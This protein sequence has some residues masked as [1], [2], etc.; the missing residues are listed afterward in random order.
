MVRQAAVVLAAI[1]WLASP[2]AFADE[3]ATEPAK[4][5]VVIEDAKGPP[6]DELFVPGLHVRH[7]PVPIFNNFERWELWTMGTLAV[8]LPLSI[9]FQSEIA[10]WRFGGTLIGSPPSF[11]VEISE[12]L[13]SG[14][15]PPSYLEGIDKF[16]GIVVPIAASL[17]YLSDGVVTA[18]RG[19]GF[20]GDVYSLHHALA[21]G[22]AFLF[23]GFVTQLGKLGIGRLRPRYELGRVPPD[24]G[25]VETF[26]SFPSGHTSI[27]FCVGS[28]L[29]RDLGDYLVNERGW[30]LWAGRIAPGVVIYSIALTIAYQRVADQDHYFSDVLI[31]AALGTT[32][33]HW[34]YSRHFDEHGHPRHNRGRKIEIIAGPTSVGVQGSF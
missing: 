22:E 21:F 12:A 5:Q 33:G 31:G 25:D 13:W 6:Q 34:I 27:S 4:P 29:F 18:A 8:A 26:L 30:G 23:T 3:A 9:I 1:A 15:E 7:V 11:D 14:P 16:G 32:I 28:Y 17:F 20:T 10:A 2:A 24:D 19:V